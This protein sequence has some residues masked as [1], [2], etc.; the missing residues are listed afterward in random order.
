MTKA[1]YVAKKPKNISHQEAASLPLVGL[2]TVQ[3]LSEYAAAAPGQHVFINVG[4]GGIG[5]FAIQY[6]KA[7]G[8]EVTVQCNS[9][10]EQLL[11]P[12]G[13]D[14]FIFYDEQEYASL[15]AVFDIVYD[16]LGGPH[17]VDSFKVVKRGGIVASIAGPPDHDFARRENL[18]LLPKLFMRFMSRHVYQAARKAGARY[19]RALTRPDGDQL[20]EITALVEAAKIKPLIDRVFDFADTIEAL[21]YVKK[22][23]SKGKV[24][25]D[26]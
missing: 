17:T 6:A 5:T 16:C 11:K 22:G 20:R 26:I 21:Q 18:G 7:L 14:H 2:T 15:G 24:V 19:V 12:L 23:K 9:R 10:D 4:A 3:H 1:S 25:I 13:V 8:L